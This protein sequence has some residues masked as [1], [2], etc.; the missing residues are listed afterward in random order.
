M[1]ALTLYSTDHT[2]NIELTL[3]VYAGARALAA[4]VNFVKKQP[5]LYTVSRND[6]KKKKG[7]KN[8]ICFLKKEIRFSKFDKNEL[9]FIAIFCYF[10]SP[11]L[12]RYIGGKY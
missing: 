1:P 10:F 8:Y 4:R 11:F 5:G 9:S 6:Q 7:K 2:R 3:R 12:S